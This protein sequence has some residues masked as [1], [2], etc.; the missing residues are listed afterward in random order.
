MGLLWIAV[1][2][3]L[4]GLF[5]G[6]WWVLLVPVA[7]WAGIALFLVVNDGWYGAGWGDFGIALNVATAILSVLLAA[8]GVGMRSTLRSRPGRGSRRRSL[9]H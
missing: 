9:P 1:A 6:R 7:L 3:G 4:I 8:A 5:V 2:C